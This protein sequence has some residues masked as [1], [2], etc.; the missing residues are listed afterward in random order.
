MSLSALREW[1]SFARKV[2]PAEPQ[3]NEPEEFAR[4]RMEL[5]VLEES[6]SRPREPSPSGGRLSSLRRV[7]GI[8][9]T[10]E[11]TWT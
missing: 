11:R 10:T 3:A 5:D 4:M 9:R 7:G 1:L 6:L 8:S 2:V